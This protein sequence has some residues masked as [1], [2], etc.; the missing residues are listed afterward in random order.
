MVF[1]AT[2]S[3]ISAISWGPVFVMEKVGST[4]SEPPTMGKQLVN[5]ITCGCESSAEISYLIISYGL[6]LLYN[7]IIPLFFFSKAR[8]V[9]TF[10]KYI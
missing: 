9:F 10:V 3:N 4:R 6:C 1:N 8:V 2:F 5:F 7:V